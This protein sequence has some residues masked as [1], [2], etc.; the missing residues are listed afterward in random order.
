MGNPSQ[1]ELDEMTEQFLADND[2]YYRDKRKRK[3]RKYEHPYL[4]KQQAQFVNSHEY[5]FSSLSLKQIKQ[6]EDNNCDIGVAKPS[7]D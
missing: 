7:F 1:K 3:A 6:C 4:T 5:P 2:P